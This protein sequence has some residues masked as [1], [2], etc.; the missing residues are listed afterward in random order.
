MTQR[1]YRQHCPLARALDQVGERWTLL[2]L[3][4]L[5]GRPRRYGELLEGL[6]GIGTNLLAARLQRLTEL[7]L[8][9][10]VARGE[11][12]AY[13]LTP[14]GR[15]LEPALRALA[16]FGL[17]ELERPR[18]GDLWRLAWSPLELQAAFRPEVAGDLDAEYELRIGEEVVWVRVRGGECRAGPGP[19]RLPDLVLEAPPAAWLALRRG[20][21]DAEALAGEPGVRLRGPLA[22]L[23]RLV[24]LFRPAASGD[25]RVGAS[26]AGEAPAPAHPESGEPQEP[27]ERQ[28]TPA[29]ASASTGTTTARAE[30]AASVPTPSSRVGTSPSGRR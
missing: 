14:R 1:T 16:R 22:S 25:D 19:A 11:A 4:D 28:E 26:P 15:A 17:E 27:T 8:V 2:V 30:R 29:W 13:A 7:G 3:R 21:L 23:R 12:R 10:G 5:L 20:R 24:G 9:E 6:P 18:Q